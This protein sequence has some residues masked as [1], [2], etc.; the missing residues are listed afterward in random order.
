MK[1]RISLLLSTV[2]I[3]IGRLSIPTRHNLGWPGSYE[4]LAHF[5]V[6]W[7]IM[8]AYYQPKVRWSAISILLATSFWELFLVL[9]TKP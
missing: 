2:L 8:V 3:V 5:W 4:A 9:S 7:L 1:L 6:M